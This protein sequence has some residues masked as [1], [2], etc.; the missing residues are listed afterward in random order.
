[1]AGAGARVA[2]GAAP[3]AGR[4]AGPENPQPG[5][6]GAWP[7]VTEMTVAQRG[8]RRLGA[9]PRP[10]GARYLAQAIRLRARRAERHRVFGRARVEPGVA[11]TVECSECGTSYDS[12]EHPFCPRCGSTSRGAAVPGAIAVAARRDPSRRRV[13]A[14]GGVLLAIGLLF[15]ASA[16]AGFLPANGEATATLV[17]LLATQPGGQLYVGFPTAGNASL[18]L[19]SV[20]AG[21]SLDNSTTDDGRAEVGLPR[22]SVRVHAIQGGVHWNR[23]VVVL[24]G[25]RLTLDLPAGGGDDVEPIFSR[26]AGAIERYTAIAMLVIALVLVGGGIAALALR[27]FP[28]AALAA[29]IGALLALVALF[30]FLLVGLLFALPFGFAAYF[31]VR[32]RRHFR[33]AGGAEPPAKSP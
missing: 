31:I 7:G 30:S 29:G 16:A 23:T 32:G 12:Q 20:D 27:I 15:L 26:A 5:H 10:E 6:T 28:L 18:E 14:S 21:E 22:A 3:E 25:D 4:G 8:H 9:M 1:M 2:A 17:D 19:F 11:E 24:E 13:Q 33:K